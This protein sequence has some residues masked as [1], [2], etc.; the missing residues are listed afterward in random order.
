MAQVIQICALRSSAR[1]AE[2]STF[3]QAD[4]S[5]G[6]KNCEDKIAL[7]LAV[8][9][10]ARDAFAVAEKEDR[11]LAYFSELQKQTKLLE[12][13]VEQT[14]AAE[15]KLNF[16]ESRSDITGCI[17]H[18]VVRHSTQMSEMVKNST[19]QKDIK[20]AKKERR[21]WITSTFWMIWSQSG[22]RALAFLVEEA[23][24]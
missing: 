1:Q 19:T 17:T 16:I 20:E 8:D 18:D 21:Q 12:K 22:I 6:W 7:I 5:G 14:Q 3:V 9:E 2:M 13:I 4:V 10:S 15:M 11:E 24:K 23:C